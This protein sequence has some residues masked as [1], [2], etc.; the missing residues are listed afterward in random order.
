MIS[1]LKH[2]ESSLI[3]GSPMLESILPLFEQRHEESASASASTSTSVELRDRRRTLISHWLQ[4]VVRPSLSLYSNSDSDSLVGGTSISP[5]QSSQ[6]SQSP[7]ELSEQEVH[8]KIFEQLSG[9][10][11]AEAVQTAQ[12]AG[13]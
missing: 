11:L 6:S 9:L 8:Y 4:E 5:S 7:S 1:T 12:D 2:T 10:L 13:R 3:A